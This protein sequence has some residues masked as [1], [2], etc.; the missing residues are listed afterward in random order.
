MVGSRKKSGKKL[1]LFKHMQLM[2][3]PTDKE[4]YVSLSG[5]FMALLPMYPHFGNNVE[6]FHPH[7]ILSTPIKLLLSLFINTVSHQSI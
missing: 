5:D 3:V 6:E 2:H 4:D 1:R 7:E